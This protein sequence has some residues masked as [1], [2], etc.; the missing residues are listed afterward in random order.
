MLLC[1]MSHQSQ[2]QQEETTVHLAYFVIFQLS[3]FFTATYYLNL[4]KL[5]EMMHFF[6]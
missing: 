6:Y 3:S 4:L 5:P 2:A 1:L